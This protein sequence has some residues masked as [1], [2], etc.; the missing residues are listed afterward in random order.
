M[1]QELM[2]H[3]L[4]YKMLVAVVVHCGLLSVLVDA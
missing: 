1:L 2:Q 3:L 4:V